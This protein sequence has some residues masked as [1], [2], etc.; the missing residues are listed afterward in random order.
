MSASQV[1]KF[2]LRR[3][4]LILGEVRNPIGEEKNFAIRRVLR[5]N[6]DDLT[7]IAD[8]VPFEDLVPTYPREQIKLGLD[9]DNISGRILDLIAPIG[10]GQRSLIIAPPKAGKTTFISSIANAIIKGEKDTDVWILLID[11]RPEEVT[12]IKENVEG[13]TV[14]ASTFDDDP[15]N[16]IKVTEEII[17]RAKMKVEDG[18]NVVILT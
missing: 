10:K 15:K 2:K 9:H 4:D 11:E 6:D 14:F 18:E 8:R 17:E 12:D 13:A 16:H 5:V 3:G 1:K 7:K